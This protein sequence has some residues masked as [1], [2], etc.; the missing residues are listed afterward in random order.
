METQFKFCSALLK[1]TGGWYKLSPAPGLLKGD[2][3]L[4]QHMPMVCILAKA[5]SKMD[6]MSSLAL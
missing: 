6:I 3:W 2:S 5:V 4:V 1:A